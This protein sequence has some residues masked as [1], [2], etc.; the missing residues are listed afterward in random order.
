[1]NSAYRALDRALRFSLVLLGLHSPVLVGQAA[2]LG[3]FE[4]LTVTPA[5]RTETSRLTDGG[6]VS[7]EGAG[8]ITVTLAGELKGRADRDGVIGVL[9]VP[10]IPF[11]TN[12]Y[13]SRKMVL[14][15]AEFTVDIHS[16]SSSYF[17]SQS[18]RAP[19]GFPS[20]H[21]FLFNTTGAPA[22]VNVY[23]YSP[24]NSS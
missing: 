3:S 14:P 11:F 9:L 24:R 8:S 22:S 16:G 23:V 12:L 20:Y 6:I 1:M 2:A 5:E 13:R 18:K 15:A 19:A 7:V 4:N 21:L 17:I 10:A